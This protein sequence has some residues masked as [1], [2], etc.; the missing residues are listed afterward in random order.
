MVT[1]PILDSLCLC[2]QKSRADKAKAKACFT[3]MYLLQ[4]ACVRVC[5]SA[6]LRVCVCVRTYA[7]VCRLH[8]HAKGFKMHGPW[9]WKRQSLVL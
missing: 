9:R 1:A 7:F 2:L 3:Y 6:C 4:T 8:V 5:V